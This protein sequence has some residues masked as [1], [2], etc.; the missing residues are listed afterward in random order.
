MENSAELSF[1]QT[2]WAKKKSSPKIQIEHTE[3]KFDLHEKPRLEKE[4]DKMRFSCYGLNVQIGHTVSPIIFHQTED[5]TITITPDMVVGVIDFTPN[6]LEDY[7]SGYQTLSLAHAIQGLRTFFELYPSDRSKGWETEQPE[8]LFGVTNERMAKFA[9]RF[10][11]SMEYNQ[12]FQEYQVIGNFDTVKE[13][14][15]KLMEQ[16]PKMVGDLMERALREQ[17]V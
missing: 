12:L 16:K 15:T 5:D 17:R 2:S 10:G 4:K 7:K 6:G 9:T 14:F 8:Y 3:K 13:Q 1:E 11:F